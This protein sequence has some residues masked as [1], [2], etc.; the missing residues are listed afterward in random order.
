MTVGHPATITTAVGLP[1]AT[2]TAHRLAMTTTAA[3]RR[4]LV[5]TTAAPAAAMKSVIRHRSA[6]TS[7]AMAAATVGTVVA[8]GTGLAVVQATT[9]GHLLRTAA[10]LRFKMVLVRLLTVVG[11]D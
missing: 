6:T 7:A 4:L 1:P 3:A 5:T 2:M 10:A 11:T 9:A 8:T